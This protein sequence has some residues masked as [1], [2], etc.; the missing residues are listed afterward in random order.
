L[1]VGVSQPRFPGFAL[2]VDLPSCAATSKD[3]HEIDG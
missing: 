1:L 2:S 3:Y